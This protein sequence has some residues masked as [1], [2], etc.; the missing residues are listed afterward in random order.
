ML[1]TKESRK[2]GEERKRNKEQAQQIENSYKHD[3]CYGNYISHHFKCEWPKYILTKNG[4]F[5]ID[6]ILSHKTHLNRFKR[7]EILQC[8]FSNHNRVT[9]R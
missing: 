1:K 3:R 8:M 2:R 7:I 6:Y 9:E 4:T 5:M